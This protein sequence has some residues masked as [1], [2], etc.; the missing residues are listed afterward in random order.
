MKV[1]VDEQ[2]YITD[3]ALIGELVNGLEISLPEDMAHFEDYF[4]AYRVR[5]GTAAFD[6]GRLKSLNEAAALANYRK[7]RE[8]ECFSVINRGTLWYEGLTAK[9][10]AELEGWYHSWLDGTSTL[11]VPEPPAWLK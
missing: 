6:T 1:K 10:R 2:G 9:Q 7:R 5:D 4:S 3:Y 11:A 8:T